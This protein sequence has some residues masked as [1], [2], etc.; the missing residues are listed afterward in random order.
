VS[1]HLTEYEFDTI[2]FNVVFRSIKLL[3]K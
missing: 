2:A 3:L 1:Q